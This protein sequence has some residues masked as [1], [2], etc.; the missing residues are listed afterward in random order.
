MRWICWKGKTGKMS[1][2]VGNAFDEL[3]QSVAESMAEIG[4]ELGMRMAEGTNEE[5]AGIFV[6]LQRVATMRQ[7][8]GLLK[9]RC[10]D[11]LSDNT[12]VSPEEVAEVLSVQ[13]P[14]VQEALV[15]QAAQAN[16][17]VEFL[18]QKESV[19]AKIE[20]PHTNGLTIGPIETPKSV[21]EAPK[22]GAHTK[23]NK[24]RRVLPVGTY[25]EA[26]TYVPYL[27]RAFLYC[28]KNDGYS[29]VTKET[30]ELMKQEGIAKPADMEK[31]GSGCYRYN[32]QLSSIRNRLLRQGVIIS[33]GGGKYML[34]DTGRAEAQRLDSQA[35]NGHEAAA[36][37]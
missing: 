17:Q 37:M 10:L 33:L 21:R 19:Q 31:T 13:T 18:E 14:I 2:T 32:A 1:K 15:D 4:M 26:Q 8:I 5:A 35:R 30:I 11:L 7:E 27:M 34:S 22:A 16:A 24:A 3:L 28:S 6:R 29:Q 23:K 20:E 25:T 9:S 36:H 12:L